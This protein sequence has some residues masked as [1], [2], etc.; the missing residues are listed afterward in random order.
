MALTY[1]CRYDAQRPLRVYGLD[2]KFYR[3]RA[4]S[5]HSFQE[6]DT[7]LFWLA[8]NTVPAA[9]RVPAHM[10]VRWWSVKLRGHVVSARTLV[11]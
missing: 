1:S 5:P 10:M 3:L 4:E 11:R 8:D 7:D 6:Y 9:H 2:G